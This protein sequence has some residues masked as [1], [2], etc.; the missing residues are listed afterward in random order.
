MLQRDVPPFDEMDVRLRAMDYVA[1][2]ADAAGGVV[3]RS[4]LEAFQYQGEPLKLIDTGR[5]VRNPRQLQACISIMSRGGA[6]YEDGIDPQDG[7]LR[8][9][10]APGAVDAGD[11]RKLRMAAALHVPI[12]WLTWLSDGFYAP[13]APVYVVDD[14]PEARFVKVAVDEALRYVVGR[15]DIST[16]RYAERLTKLRLHQPIFRARVLRA[17]GISCSVCR[18]RHPDLLD[19]AHIQGDAESGEPVVNNGLCLCKI[20]HAAYD[21]GIMGVR[22][23]YVVEIRQ[24]VLDEVDGPMLRHGLQDVHG[25]RLS[26]PT[27]VVDLPDRER[28]GARYRTFV[29]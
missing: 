1:G 21:R 5:G 7:L 8:Y 23:D 11:N 15:D 10:Y 17:Y 18:L 14:H 19:A 27:R 28:L 4:Q 25:W 24:D 3:T 26:L 12:I 2:K 13:Q 29:A 20:H 9:A 22:P 16:R 6:S